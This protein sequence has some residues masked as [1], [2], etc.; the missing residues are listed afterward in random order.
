MRIALAPLNPTVG[1]LEGNATLAI[2]AITEAREHGADLVVLPE[3]ALSGYPPKDL[4]WRR[5]F[6]DTAMQV[7]HRV[8][9]AT[10]GVAAILGSPWQEAGSSAI[11]NS[12]LL[13]REGHIEARYDKRLLPTYDVFDE[14]R[15]F[16]AGDQPLVFTHHE[17]RIGIAICEDLWRG[18]DAGLS[19]RY[20]GRPDPVAELVRNGAQLIVCPSAS[21]FVLGKS[22]AQRDILL[23]HAEQHGVALAAVNQRGGNDDLVFDGHAAVVRPL[24]GG[25][26]VIAAAS[27]PFHPGMSLHDITEDPAPPGACVDPLEETPAMELLWKA[28]TLGVRDYVHKTGFQD[29]VLGLS[30][31]IDSAVTACVAAGALGAENVLTIGMPSRYSS[32]GSV[33]DAKELA[34]SIGA[35]FRVVPIESMHEAASAA[36]NPHF[37]DLKL[38]PAPGV[39]D[40]NVQSRLRGLVVMAFS[41]KTGALLLTTGNKSELAVGYCTL[42][43]DMN[44]GLAVLS[45]VSKTQV[46]ALARWIN[47]HHSACGFSSPP[48]P[49]STIT[50]PPSA[51]LRPDQTDQDSLPPYDVLDEIIERYVERRESPT[52]I[53]SASGIDAETV[54][55]IV[56]LI[57]LNEYKRKQT[58]I[59]LKVTSV[60]FGSG[61]RYPIA[62]AWRPDRLLIQDDS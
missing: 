28:L 51:E 1:D 29:V 20:T 16:T 52:H 55:R 8:A 7:A 26:P 32:E 33:T 18:D 6:I 50:K 31:G 13:L 23:R 17:W 43:G 40:E 5:E 60:A 37:H 49:E 46:F 2:D 61:R 11:Y 39:M 48:I 58:A 57:D 35:P 4:L 19:S 59:G 25:R 22:K 30:G 3:L 34:A 42:Y 45:D 14:D 15:Y 54:A 12:A 53:T 24:E 36:I 10:N 9:H 41:N 21:P 47:D 27:A 44:G 62:Q 38:D 56:R